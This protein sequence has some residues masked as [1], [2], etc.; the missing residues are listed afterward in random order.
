M[1]SKIYARGLI[2]IT[3]YFEGVF[4]VTVED[5]D[6]DQPLLDVQ[7]PDVSEDLEGLTLALYDSDDKIGKGI[8]RKL[9]I[10]Q[11]LATKVD[12]SEFIPSREPK[13]NNL[14]SPMYM[15]TYCIL[16]PNAKSENEKSKNIRDV[17]FRFGSWCYAGQVQLVPKLSLS[18][19]PHVI[20]ALR[21]QQ[22]K[23][24][25]YCEASEMPGKS[26]FA[27]PMEYA[28]R[29]S[30]AMENELS[31]SEDALC[32]L[33]SRLAMM[34]LGD[35]VNQWLDG[36]PSQSFFEF[37]FAQD[38]VSSDA[39]NDVELIA[40]KCYN[41]NG[42][43]TMAI[44]FEGIYYL[45]VSNGEGE[46]SLLDCKFPDVAAKGRGYQIRSY[47]SGVAEWPQL[48]KVSIWQHVAAM[49]E[50]LDN[51]TRKVEEIKGK[52]SVSDPKSDN[53]ANLNDSSSTS[54]KSNLDSDPKSFDQ[55]KSK[56]PGLCCFDGTLSTK[57]DDSPSSD[58]QEE[59]A[60]CESAEGDKEISTRDQKKLK[61]KKKNDRTV[62]K[63]ASLAKE[64]RE[65][66]GMMQ[67]LGAFHHLAPM[68]KI[69]SLKRQ[70]GN[71][72][73]SI[74]VGNNDK[75]SGSPPWDK[76]GIPLSHKNIRS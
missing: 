64:L 61:R 24:D 67:N 60:I 5:G 40:T 17:L 73:K 63:E 34:G 48:R 36:D 54:L 53:H 32:N 43:I 7:F 71:I 68:K 6:G 21:I 62:L 14:S 11:S 57:G 9:S 74:K 39:H 3:I 20:P 56:N 49:D 23:L 51:N 1:C 28:A 45:S 47:P 42:L 4:Y 27:P 70:L 33:I 55:G 10:W 35:S 75:E 44:Y 29:A 72:E 8:W 12:I 66:Q 59:E 30:A 18:D 22:S 41:P 16:K 15:Q 26:I 25:F 31:L 52:H 2:F 46:Q 58:K 65:D 69:G 38:K 37:S 76:C 50:G 19:L 13:V